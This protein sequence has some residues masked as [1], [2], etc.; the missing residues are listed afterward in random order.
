MNFKIL[1]LQGTILCVFLGVQPD[2]AM[3][4]EFNLNENPGYD[5]N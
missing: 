1:L 4:A 5:D 2:V 3:A